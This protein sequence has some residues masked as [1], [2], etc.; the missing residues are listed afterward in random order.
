MSDSLALCRH[1]RRATRARYIGSLGLG[2]EK[3]LR[4]R[5]V[6]MEAKQLPT[7]HTSSSKKPE[8]TSKV[9]GHKDVPSWSSQEALRDDDG[10]GGSPGHKESEILKETAILS[11]IRPDPAYQPEWKR[12]NND[13]DRGFGHV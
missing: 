2:K 13:C 12:S 9:W 6:E 7:R 3:K 11:E 5:D 10:Y 8:V 4:L 1:L